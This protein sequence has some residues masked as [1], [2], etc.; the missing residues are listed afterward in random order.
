MVQA[1]QAPNLEQ[2]ERER[3]FVPPTPFEEAGGVDSF[4]TMLPKADGINL[5]AAGVE[6]DDNICV[7]CLDL[8]RSQIF[9]PC[10]HLVT[11]EICA[12][13]VRFWAHHGYKVGL[14]S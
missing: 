4:G 6:D 3:T 7:V 12:Q 13:R 9:S 11:C 10:G 8:D 2:L 5:S 1:P 14:Y